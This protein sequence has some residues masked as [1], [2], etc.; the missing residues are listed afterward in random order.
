MVY[1]PLTNVTNLLAN[2]YAGNYKQKNSHSMC[3]NMIE[4]RP[5]VRQ[6][7][8]NSLLLSVQPSTAI[9]T[10]RITATAAAT[11]VAAATMSR[12]S[13]KQM[14]TIC[15]WI[16]TLWNAL[17]V[18]ICVGKCSKN[19]EYGKYINTDSYIADSN[20]FVV[21]VF[22]VLYIHLRYMCF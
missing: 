7:R 8:F 19:D 5:K 22:K 14:L 2:N 18:C 3:A 15:L 9:A 13:L 4:W 21:F 10:E 17:D 16:L 11:A 12:I 6:K 20:L 1:Q